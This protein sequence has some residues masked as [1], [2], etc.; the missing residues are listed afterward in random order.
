MLHRLA[1]ALAAAFALAGCGGAE[2]AAPRVEVADAIV[3]MPATAGGPGA[4]YFKLST[5]VSARLVGLT[6][7][8]ARRIELHEEGMRRA[9]AIAVVPGEDLLFAPGGRHA[10]LFGLDASLRPGERMALTFSFEG[11]QPLT[12]EAEV[13][14]PG[15]VR[16]GD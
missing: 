10:M 3:T 15:D 6:S 11:G 1:T 2:N 7:P 14:A 4:A 16:A 8:R 9:E 13:R 5:N 12:V